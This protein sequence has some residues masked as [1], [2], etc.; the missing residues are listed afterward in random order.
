MALSRGTSV[1]AC[2]AALGAAAF[3]SPGCGSSSPTGRSAAPESVEATLAGHPI[4]LEVAAD[5][6]SRSRG[7]QGRETPPAEGE[8]MLFVF[9]EPDRLTF[10]RKELRFP[11]DVVFVDASGGVL[12]VGRLDDASEFASSPS[13][14][15]YV[16]ETAAGW[17][18]EN[19]VGRGDRLELARPPWA[20]P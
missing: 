14:A 9:A 7:L 10:A 19:A 6:A 15:L 20:S 3:F 12:A 2:A 16:I 5:T 13:G 8:G 18:E 17:A 11:V 1:F 4:R